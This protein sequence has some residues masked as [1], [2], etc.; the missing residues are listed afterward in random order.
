MK[1]TFKN[2]CN[3]KDFVLLCEKADIAPRLID[4]WLRYYNPDL[5][6]NEN[7]EGMVWDMRQREGVFS[8]VNVMNTT[9]NHNPYLV[10]LINE[11]FNDFDKMEFAYIALEALAVRDAEEV[12][13]KVGVNPLSD[14]FDVETNDYEILMHVC[15]DDDLKMILLFTRTNI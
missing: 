5:S 4:K 1:Q 6:P 15:D 14:D 9:N 2:F 11:V 12:L 7:F 13:E 10:G 3:A 8:K